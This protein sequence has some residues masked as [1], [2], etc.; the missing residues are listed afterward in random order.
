MDGSAFQPLSQLIPDL[1][2]RYLHRGRPDGPQGGAANAFGQ[3]VAAL[4]RTHK[5]FAPGRLDDSAN[6]KQDVEGQR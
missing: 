3:A 5:D 1:Q 2:A 4:A 6:V